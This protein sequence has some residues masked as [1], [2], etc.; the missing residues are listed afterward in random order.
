MPTNLI[1]CFITKQF[2][3]SLK[4]L[5]VDKILESVES[6]SDRWVSEDGDSFYYDITNE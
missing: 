2:P 5:K 3:L 1:S 6:H 4:E